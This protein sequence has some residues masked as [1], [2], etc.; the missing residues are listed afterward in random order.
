M[1]QRQITQKSCSLMRL[2]LTNESAA[3]I[4]PT[5]VTA[6]MLSCSCCSNPLY[7]DL[8]IL[9]CAHPITADTRDSDM[10]C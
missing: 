6:V 10:I 8:I 5:A 3:N 1:C 4:W 7:P 9:K 2:I